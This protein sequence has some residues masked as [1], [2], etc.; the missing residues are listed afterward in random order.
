M[1]IQRIKYKNNRTENL[2]HKLFTHKKRHTNT[3]NATHWNLNQ[4]LKNIYIRISK[5]EK[6]K[7]AYCC[8]YKMIIQ[9]YNNYNKNIQ[10][11]HVISLSCI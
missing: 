10:C 4:Q 2:N 6:N 3:Y 7:V 8:I 11:I 1:Y 9:G 5:D